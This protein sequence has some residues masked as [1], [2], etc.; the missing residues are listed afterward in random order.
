[1]NRVEPMSGGGLAPSLPNDQGAEYPPAALHDV[2]LNDCVGGTSSS[3]KSQLEGTASHRSHPEV[4]GIEE[5]TGGERL[6]MNH[7]TGLRL[8]HG[9]APTD[10]VAA[11]A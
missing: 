8:V 2:L 11:S 10:R 6:Y 5:Y 1:M 9:G 4:M 7:K 3:D